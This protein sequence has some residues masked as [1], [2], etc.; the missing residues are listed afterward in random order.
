MKPLM[1]LRVAFTISTIVLMGCNDIERGVPT[2]S[3]PTVAPTVATT[4]TVQ[5]FPPSKPTAAISKT[6][7]SVEIETLSCKISMAQVND[8]DGPLNVRSQPDASV[9][10]I[11]GQL[12]NGTMVTVESEANGWLQITNPISGWI[13]QKRTDS[14]CNQKA[15]RVKFAPG[16][17]S[18]DLRDRILGSGNHRYLFEASAGQSLTLTARE[19]PL[20]IVLTPE[21]TEL[22]AETTSNG[23]STW[24]GQL[25]T[26][27]EYTLDFPSNFR[28]F[29]YETSIELN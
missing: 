26:S 23:A 16:S 7:K 8:P 9:N 10:N 13:S 17:V 29:T 28:G 14:S 2:S 19:G 24:T 20:P 27:G 21:G 1:I 22:N 18:F 11:V 6:P 5:E 15:S 25:S 3:E 12:Q 4:P